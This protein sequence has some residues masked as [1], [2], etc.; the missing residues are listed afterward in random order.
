MRK[1][2]IVD[3][4]WNEYQ[5]KYL[6]CTAKHKALFSE[7]RS[8]KTKVWGEEIFS[9]A[10]KYPGITIGIIRNI[11]QELITSTLPQ[12]QAV[13]DWDLTGEQFN[14]TDKILRMR[15]KSLILCFALDRP[16][17]VKKLKNVEL[18]HVGGDQMEEM[19]PDVVDMAIGRLSQPGMPN[20]S[21][22]IGNFEGKGFYW[23]MFFK[24]PLDVHRGRF[25]KAGVTKER[26][27]GTFC[28]INE[29]YI[30]FW[31]PPF[32]NE[33]NL[34]ANYYDDLIRSHSEAF[35]DKYVWGLPTGN[36]G[37]VHKDYNEHIHLVKASDYY[38]IP[39]NPLWIKVEGMDYG[40]S[41]PT[42]WLMVAYDRG[43]QSIHFYD[44]YYE[45]NQGVSSH[46][47]KVK[48]LR[49]TYGNPDVT[50]GCPRA[51][52]TEKDGRTPAD[53]YEE[54]HGIL[55]TPFPIGIDA[56]VEI[57]NR[58]FKLG[59]IKIFE[60]CQ[61]LRRQIEGTTWK[62]LEKVENHALEA[63]HRVASWID[64]N[65]ISNTASRMIEAESEKRIDR[66]DRPL[67]A[68]LLGREF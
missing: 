52:A 59:K 27:Y 62:N 57:V 15:N 40:V 14:K 56:R 16:D 60:R 12:L 67:T 35:C 26:D 4:Y 55:L 7:F 53:E 23:D 29:D 9:I 37:L 45:S 3:I 63:F 39:N 10:K 24:N 28:G 25:T 22:W 61:F 30:G 11:H 51:F 38:E 19:H 44:E 17:D 6:E 32:L 68:G 42:C 41:N 34:P 36:A 46:G 43:T 48:A 5:V 66:R 1:Q 8:G 65:I 33:E 50:I 20:S 49:D 54:Q 58:L 18:G 47:P 64:V 2:R 13:Y 31:P 21:S